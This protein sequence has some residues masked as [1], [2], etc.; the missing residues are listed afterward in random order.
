MQAD[1][2][3]ATASPIAT[4]S[5]TS[6]S[7]TPSFPTRFLALGR[8]DAPGRHADMIADLPTDP[9]ELV[10]LT[11]N[12]LIHQHV[13]KWVYDVDLSPERARETWLRTVEEKLGWLGEHGYRHIGDPHPMAAHMV[14]ICRDFSV[15]GAALF[16]LAGIPAR[17]RCGFGTYFEPGKHIDH[18]VIEWWNAARGAWQL[19]DAQ[20][21]PPTAAK[22]QLD[23]DPMDVPRNRFL[24]GPV[25]WQL[26]RSGGADA[27]SFGIFQWWGY[28]YLCCN[29][30]LDVNALLNTP[31]QPWDGWDGYKDLP[32]GQW[33]EADWAVVD[34]LVALAD[35]VDD[36]FDAFRAFVAE[37]DRIRV[38]EDWGLIRNYNDCP[39][40]V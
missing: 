22:L 15:L 23:F 11:Q 17:A 10:R 7:N 27:Q 38:P 34:R 13:A 1:S 9:A 28:D 25:A 2:F 24:T 16:K 39:P 35:R 30:M 8:M 31:M 29:L 26:A 4:A 18:W 33:T 21:D 19:T 32:S 5:E 20:M 36:D 37:D 12:A 14:G 6:A 3:H 40:S